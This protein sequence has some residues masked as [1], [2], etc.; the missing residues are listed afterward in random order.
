VVAK[1]LT[2]IGSFLDEIL[3][4][5]RREVAERKRRPRAGELAAAVR[6]AA[7]PRGFR[8]ALETAIA[9][10]R[11]ATIIAE[12]KRRSPSA[13]ALR[14]GGARDDLPAIAAMYER[15][16]ASALSVLTD[17]AYFAGQDEDI[18]ACR[19]A[20]RLPALRKDFLIDPWQIAE[21]RALGADAVLLIVR[22]LAP[23]ALRELHAAAAEHALDVLAEVHDETELDAALSLSGPEPLIGINN[24]DLDT[25]TTDLAATERVVRRVPAGRIVVSE[26][27]IESAEDVRRLAAA[28]ASAFL[29]GTS[30]LRSADLEAKTREL[31]EAL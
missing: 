25:L 17:A 21:S 6:T 26:S 9:A 23:A 29:V 10:G 19:A 30:L 13:G 12:V 14:G 18:A 2:A 28:G 4:A 5:K 7:P 1:E 8:R 22:A 15:A 16:G 11:G 3:E 24:R 31:V 27:G 20:S